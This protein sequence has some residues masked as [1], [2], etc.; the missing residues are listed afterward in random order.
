MV[1]WVDGF[2]ERER[3]RRL[4]RHLLFLRWLYRERPGYCAGEKKD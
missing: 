1:Q 4:W 3:A 2:E